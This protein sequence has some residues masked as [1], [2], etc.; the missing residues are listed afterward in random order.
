M[1][2]LINSFEDVWGCEGTALPFLVLA[3]DG[4]EWSPSYLCHFTLEEIAP[5]NHRTG[6]CYGCY[7]ENRDLFSVLGL[8]PRFLGCQD[9]NLVA[10]STELLRLHQESTIR[11]NIWNETL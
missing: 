3:P 6:G 5:G 7:G 2:K 11:R 9:G 1:L 10:I 4:D 8:K